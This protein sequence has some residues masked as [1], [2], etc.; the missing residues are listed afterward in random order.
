MAQDKKHF[1]QRR[2][3]LR[4][5]RESFM[6]QWKDLS[7]FVSPRRGRFWRGNEQNK[8]GQHYWNSI[9]NNH[10][11][12]S[13]RVATNGLFA[14]VMSPTQPWFVLTVNDPQLA[15]FA[16]VR[17]WL[18]YVRELI[19]EVF[20]ASN[21]YVAAPMMMSE[22]L[23]FGTGCMSHVDDDE[24]VARFHTHTIGSY[25][26]AQDSTGR[27]DTNYREFQA[28]VS[29]IIKMFGKRNGQISSAVHNQ[30]DRGNYDAW[31]PVVQAVEPNENFEPD[32]LKPSRQPY[33]SAYY[34]PG[35]NLD[36]FLSRR[37]FRQFPFYCPRWE[38]TNED[39]YG[40]N[41]PGMT[42]LG[43]T[44]QLQLEEKRKAQAIDK[45]V[46]P[47]MHGPASLRNQRISHLPAGATLYDSAGQTSELRPLYTVTPQ[48]Q[49]LRLDMDAVENRIGRAFYTDLFLAISDMAGIQPKN[50]LELTYRNQ[51]R[52]IQLGA[53]LIRQN[54]EFLNLLIDRVFN[55]L[56]RAD[57]IPP[58]PQEIQGMQLEPV[59]VSVLAMAQQSLIT[60]SI[61]RTIAFASNLAA[62][63]WQGA[64][65]KIDAA[66]AVDEYARL[67][68]APPSIIVP[69]AVLAEQAEIQ[70]Q[71]QQAQEMLGTGQQVADIAATASQAKLDK[72]NLAGQAAEALGLGATEGQA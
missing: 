64:L 60:A 46:A 35:N 67:V 41:C 24:T 32:S 54:T 4:T 38:L 39:I 69:D 29:Q 25:M 61:D 11:T 10:A 48:L 3:S 45:H 20:N 72:G 56:V 53:P 51:E 52:L 57:L 12:W 58:A 40:T 63:G 65:A 1:E 28:T 55:Q 18:Y 14:G 37:G 31:Y 33:V 62:A 22:Q 21:L 27:V 42:A 26:I 23:L 19:R 36:A 47:P 7:E 2:G 30:Y 8:G 16:P 34:E 17:A 70:N 49:D 71:Q 50:Q 6:T 68:G 9:I 5:E 43:D 13:L 44:R 66:Q 15:D 59:Y